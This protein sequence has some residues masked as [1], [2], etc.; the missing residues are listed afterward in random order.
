L[1][2]FVLVGVDYF[3]LESSSPQKGFFESL[4]FSLYSSALHYK[5]TEEKNVI[6][7]ITKDNYKNEN[8]DERVNRLLELAGD[9]KG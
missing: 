3:C 1:K 9:L 8:L 5:M 4:L 2:E 7:A 6:K